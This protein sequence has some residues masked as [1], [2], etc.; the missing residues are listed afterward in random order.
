MD[1]KEKVNP[2]KLGV[3]VTIGRPTKNSSLIL[4][5]GNEKDINSVQSE[6]QTRLGTEYEVDRP[7]KHVHRIKV[8]GVNACEHRIDDEK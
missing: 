7:K 8:V 5:C 2:V 6:I 4:S 3:G 1:L